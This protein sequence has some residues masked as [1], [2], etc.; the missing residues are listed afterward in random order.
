VRRWKW[1]KY[2][3]Q[4]VDGH[5]EKS[6]Y[7]PS[8][9][10]STMPV[11]SPC[12]SIITPVLNAGATLEEML[13]SL[14]S[15][16]MDGIEHLL[17]DAKSSDATLEIAAKYPDL[18]IHSEEDCGIYDGMNKGAHL[19]S[20]IWLLFLQAD[21]WLPEGTLRA[22][23]KAL[24]EYPTA[25]ILCGS[26][27]AV[28]ISSGIWTTLWSVHH[29][30]PKKL[31]VENIALGEPMINARLIRRDLFLRLGG[32]SLDY[33]LASD[34]DFLLRAA[35]AGIEQH[36][37]P[38]LTY[39]YRWHSGSSTMTEGNKLTQ[40]LSAENLSIAKK[41]LVHAKGRER[42]S[43]KKWHTQLTV[44]AAMNALELLERKT[45]LLAA[46]KG[47]QTDPLWPFFCAAEIL[48]ALPGFLA[49][50]GKTRSQLIR[51]ETSR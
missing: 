46:K 1:A 30:V 19:A 18:S 47:I 21:D 13:E 40:Q 38:M 25:E 17:I 7:C 31:T 44:Q 14:H 37:L 49:R 36:E 8:S 29:G 45:F 4:K 20:G 33:F 12:I 28:K 9:F 3:E 5:L 51:E 42:S 26:A 50:G 39:R 11:I 24:K 6:F 32:F 35:A 23:K 16:E 48:R 34:R 43:F 22:Y 15:Q 27:E 2:Y 10:L 41:H